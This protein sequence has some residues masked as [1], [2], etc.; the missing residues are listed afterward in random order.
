MKW[1][2]IKLYIFL[3]I[4]V[5]IFVELWYSYVIYI[6]DVNSYGEVYVDMYVYIF[7]IR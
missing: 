4:I 2:I 5:S 6:L 1:Y 7:L 3:N